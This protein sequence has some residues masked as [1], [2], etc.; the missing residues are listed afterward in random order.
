MNAL[1]WYGTD[2][3]RIA[4]VA[5]PKILNPRDAIIKVNPAFH[6]GLTMRMG[7]AH[8]MRYMAPLLD[9]VV[10]GEIDPSFVITHRL[11]LDEAPG[12]YR[13]FRDKRD[14]CIKV[15]MKP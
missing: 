7:Q 9:R 8:T 12:A 5:E 11:R 1:C 2:D 15:V 13:M 10:R 3:V 14:E 4:R 6:K